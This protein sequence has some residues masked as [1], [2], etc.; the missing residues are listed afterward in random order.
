MTPD[1]KTLT[2]V[3]K[4]LAH[5]ARRVN[6]DGTGNDHE[7]EAMARRMFKLL[8]E[9]TLPIRYIVN[10]GAEVRILPTQYRQHPNR[11]SLITR[12]VARRRNLFLEGHRL[13]DAE[14]A[15]AIEQGFLTFDRHGY[16]VFVRLGDVQVFF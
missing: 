14:A 1:E 15:V 3:K 16:T 8:E 5:A 9:G 10:A 7:A 2:R 12:V 11:K 4:I 13:R 6:N